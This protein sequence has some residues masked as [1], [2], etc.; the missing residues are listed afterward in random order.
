VSFWF[1]MTVSVSIS[2]LIP[3]SGR[4]ETGNNQRGYQYEKNNVDWAFFHRILVT[5]LVWQEVVPAGLELRPP[6]QLS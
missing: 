6:L 1:W 2:F 4:S 3:N 5:W